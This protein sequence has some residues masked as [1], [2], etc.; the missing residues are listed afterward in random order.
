MEIYL[1]ALSLILFLTK[2]RDNNPSHKLDDKYL[3]PRLV[4]RD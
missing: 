3:I 1:Q 2:D 4:I